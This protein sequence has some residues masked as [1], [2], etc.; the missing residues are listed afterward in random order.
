M[1][2]FNLLQQLETWKNWNTWKGFHWRW[3]TRGIL[4]NIRKKLL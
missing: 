2:R 3:K 4:C 1:H